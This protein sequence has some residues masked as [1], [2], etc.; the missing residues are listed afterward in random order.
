MGWTTEAVL[1]HIQTVGK[2]ECQQGVWYH[3]EVEVEHVIYLPEYNKD[4][5]LYTAYELT[6]QES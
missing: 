6:G 2:F 1:A 4:N 5:R 3:P